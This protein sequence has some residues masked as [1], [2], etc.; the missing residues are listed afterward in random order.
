MT[1]FMME[2]DLGIPDLTV[3]QRLLKWTTMKAELA[4]SGVNVRQCIK[5]RAGIR[6]CYIFPIVAGYLFGGVIPIDNLA[7]EIGNIESTMNMI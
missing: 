2:I 5:T 3:F 1:L 4:A 7:A 6:A